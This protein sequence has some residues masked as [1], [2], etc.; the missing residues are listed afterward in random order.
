MTADISMGGSAAARSAAKR[1]LAV[2]L[3]V[4]FVIMLAY[5]LD[6]EYPAIIKELN[7]RRGRE[8]F[9]LY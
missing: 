8:Q 3:V 2:F 1:R 7:K 4:T 9:H 6:R 5:H